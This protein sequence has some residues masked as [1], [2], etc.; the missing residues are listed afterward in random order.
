MKN[1][2]II[3]E[4][5]KNARKQRLLNN[6]YS[7]DVIEHSKELW[8]NGDEFLLS[9][10]DHG[11]KRLIY[12][13][14]DYDSVDR[15]L[16]LVKDGEYY[17][18]FM[19]NNHTEYIPSE[20]MR[21][22]AMMRMANSDCSSVFEKG[23]LIVSYK[24]SAVIENATE[25]DTEEIN[26]LLWTCFRTEISHLL[27][28]KELCEKIQNGQF[29]VHRNTDGHID[30]LLQ[31]DV[32]PKKFYINQVVNQTEKNV[33]HAILLDRLEKYVSAGGR[34][35]YAWVEDANVASLK[36][37][38]KYGMKHDGMWSMIYKLER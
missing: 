1:T 25:K 29:T 33:I 37:H 35:L 10:E 3:Y 13:A 23:S 20:S 5:V 8:E 16:N 6:C 34:Y 32:M 4:K 24:D 17:L 38:E 7:M 27:S 31:A 12:F 22:G 15:L 2:E 11:I 18:E 26:R 21:V 30:A 28:N 19:T 36:F 14:K 9:Y